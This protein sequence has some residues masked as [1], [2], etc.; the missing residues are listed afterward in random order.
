MQA[1]LK[2]NED[3]YMGMVSAGAT[4]TEGQDAV[5]SLNGAEFISDTNVFE[6]NGLTLTVQNKTSGDET[7]TLTTG[8]DTDGIYD[9]IKN[10]FTEYNKL[11][12]EM[13]SLYNAE[14]SKGYDPL[15][16][17]EKEAMADSE[18]EEWEKKIKDSLLRRDSTLGTVKDSLKSIMLKGATVNGKQMYLSDFGINTLGYFNAADNE[19]G[20]YHINGDKDD[21]SVRNEDDTLRAMIAAD[22]DSVISFFTQLANNVHDDLMNK[23]SATKLSSAL[24]VYNDKEMKDEYD[25]YTEKIAKQEEK[26]NALM[27]KWYSKF[28]KMETA[29]SKLESKNNAVSSMFGG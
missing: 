14:S 25:A 24:T 27:D 13:D 28:S 3:K 6:I 18:I 26:L 23:M 29:L 22:P 12:N 9:M 19:K 16:S 10:F 5:I 8:E 1:D 15:T 4:K 2:T 17:E 21:A 11:I 20:A 7:V